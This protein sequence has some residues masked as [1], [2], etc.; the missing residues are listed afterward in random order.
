MDISN[1]E[2]K[3]WHP[4]FYRKKVMANVHQTV[5]GHG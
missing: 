3:Y 1:T 2:A 4:F 5:K